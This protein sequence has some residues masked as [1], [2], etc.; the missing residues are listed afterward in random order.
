VSCRV[1][2]KTTSALLLLTHT[3]FS[4]PLSIMSAH[5]EP[6]SLA[7]CGRASAGPHYYGQ[8]DNDGQAH[9][10]GLVLLPDGHIIRCGVWVHGTLKSSGYGGEG[11]PSRPAVA[12]ASSAPASCAAASAAPAAASAA[13]GLDAAAA[14]TPALSAE[15]AL[16]ATDA[17]AAEGACIVCFSRPRDCIIDCAHFAL[18]CTCARQIQRCP[19]CRAEITQRVEKR[20]LFC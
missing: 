2:E 8:T 16:G 1:C 12:A 5:C 6:L 9:G 17:A 18:C 14:T 19:V 15:P 10:R 7:A 20:L 11:M 4:L 3:L 13:P